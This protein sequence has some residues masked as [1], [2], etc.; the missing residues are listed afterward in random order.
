VGTPELSLPA[1]AEPLPRRGL[2]FA[3]VSIALFMAAVDGTI[4]ATA[5][6]A[7]QHDLGASVIWSGWTISIYALGQALTMPVAGRISDQFGRKKVFVLSVVLFTVASLCCGAASNIYLLVLLRAVQSIGGGAFMPS[8]TGIVADHFG[9]GRD[10]ALGMFT[11]ILPIGGIFGPIA[12]GLFTDFWS[13]RGVFLVNVPIGIVLFVL[14]VKFVPGGA[15]RAA[16]R[17]DMR[18]VALLGL[19]VLA[20]MFGVT[21]LGSAQISLLDPVFLVCEAL[22]GL[23]AVLFIR[24][25]KRH[26]APFIPF[27]LMRGRGFGIMNFVN[28]CIGAFTIGLGSLVPLYAQARFGINSVAAGIL[29]TARA[30]GSIGVAALTVMVMRR[31]GHRTPMMAGFVVSAVGLAAMVLPPHGVSPYL[32]LTISTGVTGIGNGM[33]VPSSNNAGLQLAPE[34]AA[35]IAGLR[36]LFRQGGAIVAISITTAI[37][38]RSGDPGMS[39][40][41]V[42]LVYSVFM[43]AVL[44]LLV[45]VPDHRGSW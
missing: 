32:W 42:F 22:A 44:P 15:P 24:H 33:S 1:I 16:S 25:A 20:A 30:A 39:L 12:G 28:L 36:G 27:E 41:H 26:Q 29:L 18:G 34:Q 45:R 17:V 9:A 21:Y 37:V 13:W 14:A 11:S 7:I 43:I 3:I 35:A 2:I 6:P 5:L 8:A 19:M 10:R 23:A 4:V 40:A 38:A 31:T